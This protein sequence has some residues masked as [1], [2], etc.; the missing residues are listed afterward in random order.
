MR[1]RMV[2]AAM[3]G[4]S[5]CSARSI[6]SGTSNH[7]DSTPGDQ[8]AATCPPAPI[9]NVVMYCPRS[10]NRRSIR[11]SVSSPSLSLPRDETRITLHNGGLHRVIVNDTFDSVFRRSAGGWQ[12]TPPSSGALLP[13]SV[14]VEPGESRRWTVVADTTDLAEPGPGYSTDGQMHRLR[15][16]PGQY[17]FGTMLHIDGSEQIRMYSASFEVTGERPPLVPSNRVTSHSRNEDTLVV[18]T[19]T[20]S[21]HENARRVSLVADRLSLHPRNAATLSLFEL[22]NPGYLRPISDGLFVDGDLTKLLRDGF[23]IVEPADARI[24]VET[25]DTTRPPLGLTE[26]ESLAVTYGGQSW[27]LTSREGW[28]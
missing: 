22:Y 1:R 2:L 11:V 27:R 7:G 17:A 18:R 16:T 28:S 14:G 15:F 9:S 23:A 24:R 3:A 4:L 8:P 6:W 19:Q 20:E 25:V 5:G 12:Y 10:E 21:E 13:R 26:N